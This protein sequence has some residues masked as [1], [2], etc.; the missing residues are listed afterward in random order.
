MKLTQEYIEKCAAAC[1][2]DVIMDMTATPPEET[3]PKILL[4]AQKHCEKVGLNLRVVGNETVGQTL[5]GLQGPPQFPSTGR[6]KKQSKVP[7]VD[8]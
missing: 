4:H 2:E 5:S 7:R 1:Y 3:L 6:L 8:R